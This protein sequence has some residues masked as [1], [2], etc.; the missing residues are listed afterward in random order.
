LRPFDALTRLL[1]ALGVPADQV[2]H[3]VDVAAALYRSV[4]ADKRVLVVL[5]N[6]RDAAQVRPLLPGSPGSL[7]LVTTRTYLGGLVARDGAV[8]LQLHALAPA[9]A[10]ALLARTLGPERTAAE[11][12]A[13]AELARLCGYLPLALRIAAANLA[14][15]PTGSVATY[16]SRLAT[17]NRLAALAVDGEPGTGVRA[18]FD[19][20]YAALPSQAQRL[21]RLLGVVPGPDLSVPAAAALTGASLE[22]AADL[23]DLLTR[24][25]LVEARGSDRYACHDLLRLYAAD[26]TSTQDSKEAHDTALERLDEHYLRTADAAARR[27]YPQMLRLPVPETGAPVTFK[28]HA[29]ALAWLTVER[30]NLVAVAVNAERRGAYPTAW[31][32]ADALRGHFYAH[33]VFVDW[34]AVAYAGHAAAERSGD[35]RARAAAEIGLAT[36][37]YS[38]GQLERAIDRYT[39]GLALAREAAWPAGESAVLGNLGAA[40]QRMGQLRTSVDYYGLALAIDERIGAGAALAPKYANLGFTCGELGELALAVANVRQALAIQ[41]EFGSRD[42]EADSLGLLGE[43]LHGQG[44]FAEAYV[45]LTDARAI[46]QA[47]SRELGEAIMDVALGALL[48]DM[49]RLSQAMPLLRDGQRRAREASSQRVELAA[50]LAQSGV[51]LC[52]GDHDEAI[53]ASREALVMARATDT[54]FAEVEAL[55]GLALGQ[56]AGGGLDGASEHARIGLA[57]AQDRGYQVL[58]GQALGVLGAISLRRGDA[59]RALDDAERAVASHVITGHQLGEA[60]AHLIAER[61][62]LVLDRPAEASIHRRRSECLFAEMRIAPADHARIMLPGVPARL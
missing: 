42:G 47:D 58:E 52:L 34:Q 45:H 25:H 16:V 49:G 28:D 22:S 62:L 30:P 31:L 38:Q 29:A 9:D 26:Q 51:H 7:V 50:L 6:A 8:G 53:D 32:L 3:E 12:D 17:G 46:M 40:Y 37:L 20:S 18:A 1:P 41:R 36:L 10:H 13:V 48:R 24:A 43:L 60:R 23:L 59:A 55:I 35:H 33:A 61:S 19:L 11:P 39:V 27:L 57:V 44:H 21:F 4:L 5:D 15:R 2:P 14:A 56:L 54:H